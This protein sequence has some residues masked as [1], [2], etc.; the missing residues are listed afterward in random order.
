MLKFSQLEIAYRNKKILASSTIEIPAARFVALIGRNGSGK[1]SLLRVLSRLQQ[2]STGEL[3]LLNKNYNSYSAASFARLL[4]IVNTSRIN[5]PYLNIEELVSLGRHP[6][7]SFGGRLSQKDQEKIQSA[8]EV[9]GLSHMK[10]HMLQHCSD[11]ERQ[12]AM[13]ARALAQDT[14][15]LLLDE[16]TAHLDFVHRH[17]SFQLLKKLAAE[18]EKLI[19]MATHEIELALKYADQILVLHDAQ[20]HY[21]KPEELKGSELLKTI[22]EGIF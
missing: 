20:L 22:F 13:L 3:F 14:K 10:K 6:H 16:I 18:E 21:L 17:Q 4:S 19:I 12:K 5:F 8:I 2:S 7:L 11:G 15:V 1:S 9:C